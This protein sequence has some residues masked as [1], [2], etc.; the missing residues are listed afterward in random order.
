LWQVMFISFACGM[1]VSLGLSIVKILQ[2]KNQIW[3]SRKS[4]VRLQ[5]ELNQMR[6]ASLQ[7]DVDIDLGGLSEKTEDL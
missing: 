3:K 1:I 7:D 2:L 4:S 5:E 6:S